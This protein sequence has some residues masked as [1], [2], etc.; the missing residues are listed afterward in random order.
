MIDIYVAHYLP[1]EDRKTALMQRFENIGIYN[2]TWIENE[3]DDYFLDLYYESESLWNYRNS[4]L[5]YKKLFPF[6]P[7]SRALKS[8]TFKHY[9]MLLNRSRNANE[10]ALVLE[11]DIIFT[12]N[13]KKQLTHN[14]ENT[15]GYWDL[16]FIGDGCNLHIDNQHIT[17]DKIAYHK[18]HPA[19]KCT[20]SFLITKKAATKILSTFFPY[21]LPIDFQLN[22]QLFVH[23]MVVY[24]WEPTL[25]TQGSQC[26]L[27]PSTMRDL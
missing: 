10:F 27:Y 13:F 4:L 1:Q 21:V 3:P 16:I 9:K 18:C 6:Y 15:P 23:D 24:W 11:N 12:N 26:G 20:D 2:V 5:D 14:L 8:L 17:T 22:Y 19:T 25:I 7:L